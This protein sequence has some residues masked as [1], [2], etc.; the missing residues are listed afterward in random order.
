MN[1]SVMRVM[2]RVL[3]VSILTMSLWAPASQAA[4]ISSDEVVADHSYQ[5]DRERIRSLFDRA[6][7]R[8]KLQA[9]GVSPASAK[10]RVDA[11]T[12]EEVANISG[13]LDNLPAG[14][15]IV[16]VAVFIFLVLLLTDILR[17]TKVFPFTKPIR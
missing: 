11:L 8:A 17:L 16:G 2:S 4:L 3:I 13:K 7:V 1:K 15:D 9:K 14:G 10:A 6:D 12:D 5:A